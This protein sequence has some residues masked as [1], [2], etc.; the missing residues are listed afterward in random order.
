MRTLYT[1]LWALFLIA[2]LGLI[3]EIVPAQGSGPGMGSGQGYAIQGYTGTTG[4]TGGQSNAPGQGYGGYGGPAGQ[5]GGPTGTS[6]QGG[7]SGVPGQTY[8][9][10]SGGQGYGNQGY[11]GQPQG[12]NYGGG[13]PGFQGQGGSNV[14]QGL[15]VPGVR[16]AEGVVTGVDQPEGC[17]RIRRGP[18][19]QFEAFGCAKLGERLQLTGNFSRDGKWLELAG[20]GWVWAAQVGTDLRPTQAYA[21]PARS[22]GTKSSSGDDDRIITVYSGYFPSTWRDRGYY[23]DYYGGWGRP[24]GGGHRHWGGGGKWKH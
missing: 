23:G 14:T 6:G 10:G 2:I 16:G 11:G 17:L 12:Q 8:G 3:P 22:G 7:Q 5:G 24:W 19:G 1:F 20:G 4:D 15:G 21:G 13:S 9:G 18:S